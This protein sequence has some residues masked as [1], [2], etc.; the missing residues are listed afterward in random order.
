MSA[1]SLCSRIVA[2]AASRE[3]VRT[4]ARRM[5]KHDV[6]TLVVLEGEDGVRPTGI[7]TDRDLATR[8]LAEDRDPDTATIA[9]VMSHPVQAVDEHTPVDE[10]MARMGRAGV[11]RLVVTG[12]GGRLVGV[13]S[14]DDVIEAQ[15]RQ[16]AAISR[17]I[18]QQQPMI[19]A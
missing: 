8:V 17:I 11:R 16:A 1:G 13:L 3:T 10:A 4:A 7:L 9:E 14:L 19:P 12:E 15:A 2:T 5:L 18:E 6:G